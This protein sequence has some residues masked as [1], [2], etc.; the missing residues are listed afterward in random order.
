MSVVT[1]VVLVTLRQ[2]VARH[3]RDTCGRGFWQRIP[4]VATDPQTSKDFVWLLLLTVIGF[5]FRDR[6][7]HALV[8]GARN[9]D[10]PALV[11]D[12]A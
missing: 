9:A 7:S 5:A 10:S 1:F 6:R 11:V 8:D 4:V 3:Y 2:R 12:P